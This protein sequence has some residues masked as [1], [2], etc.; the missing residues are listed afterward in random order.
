MCLRVDS[1]RAAASPGGA[2]AY[3]PALNGMSRIFYKRCLWL[4]LLSGMAGMLLFLSSSAFSARW[5][6][7]LTSQLEQRGVHVAFERLSLNLLGGLVARE[8][9]IYND[10]AR[11]N[12]LAAVDRVNLEFDYGQLMR[13][14]VR[15]EGLELS[16]ANVSLPVDPKH[17]D[18]TV[19]ELRDF[20][21]RVFLRDQHLEVAHATG[22]LA[23]IR[24]DLTA[25]LTLSK[26]PDSEEKR[27]AQRAAAMRRLEVMREYR[28][29]IQLALDW[30]GRF[31]FESPPTLVAHARG[32]TE[33]LEALEVELRFAARNFSYRSYQCRELLAE[34]GMAGG[35]VDLRRLR[36][37]DALGSL[38]A[39]ATW[40]RGDEAVDFRLT[41]NA[42]LTSAADVLLGTEMLREVVFYDQGPSLALEG[43]WFFGAAAAGMKRPLDAR[44]EIHCPRFTSRGEVFE[45][46]SASFGVNSL[47]LYVRDG[48]LRHRTGS[49]N[50]QLL[51]H[52]TQGLRY[53]ATLKMD[54]TSFKPFISR[55]QTRELIERFKFDRD[56]SI[57]VKMEGKGPSSRFEECLNTGIAELRGGEYRGLR[58]ERAEGRLEFQ[59]PHLRFWDAKG[60]LPEGLAEVDE[61]VVNNHEKWV[62][63]S[64]VRAQCDPVPVLRSFAPQV[65]D[66]VAIYRLPA[67]TVFNVDGVFG[68]RTPEKTDCKVSFATAEGNG[69]YRLW[70]RDFL[71]SAPQGELRFLQDNL[72]FDVRG[73]IFRGAM[74]AKGRTDLSKDRDEFDVTVKTEA[75]EHAFFGRDLTFEKATTVV[76]GRDGEITF[77]VN[78]RTLD[79]PLTVKGR[80]FSKALRDE[81]DLDLK[82]DR[83]RWEVFGKDLD[84]LMA[85]ARISGRGG[86]F[87][88]EAT[89]QL[90]GGQFEARGRNDTRPQRDTFAA[91]VKI[92]SLSFAEFARTYAPSYETEGD[93]TGHFNFSG[94]EDNAKALRGE[95]VAII[96]NGNLYAVPILGPLT[97]LLGGFLPAPIK[98]YN[99]AKEANCTFQVADGHVY[100]NNLE[101]LTATFRLVAKG[102]ANFIEDK[103][104]FDAQARIRGLPGLVLR[105][106]SE[107][108]EY[109]ARG[110]IG[111]PDWKPRLFNLGAGSADS[112]AESGKMPANKASE[113]AEPTEGR[114][115][116]LPFFRSGGSAP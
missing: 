23:G 1:R 5:Q 48:V 49:A 57:Y 95:G 97:P 12:L 115:L 113:N 47:G 14:R 9:R 88:F 30:L 63:L 16:H 85:N 8:V 108:L 116:R 55:E 26:A 25:E 38:D 69:V 52:E 89:S 84:F 62:R 77:D 22:E 19:I 68:F 51:V 46:L 75:F 98:G 109:Q 114:K 44:G 72:D 67:S 87:T 50:L 65:A 34:G 20:S 73:R 56:S 106:V 66:P 54:P 6:A 59:G 78:A 40:R 103:V 35:V 33:S 110:S 42:D 37:A 18:L 94:E 83:L 60:E 58:F 43:R 41:S 112:E 101:A 64:G 107:L 82:M 76:A 74:Q 80:S 96:L 86:E 32:A 104:E 92:N 2:R 90:M 39:M 11:E 91:E 10:S 102:N 21:A 100:T 93:L 31:E 71:I 4:A 61:V 81:L 27:K 79:S 28:S 36:L 15:I 105:P 13:G 29:Q 7:Y 53:R 3:P 24:I 111:E 17:P 70:E 45:G 99:V